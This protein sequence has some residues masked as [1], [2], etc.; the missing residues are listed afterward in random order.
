MCLFGERNKKNNLFQ[1][2][3]QG[4]M[5]LFVNKVL[6]CILILLMVSSI[7]FKL[8][9]DSIGY[10]FERK[11]KYYSNVEN[12]KSKRKDLFMKVGSILFFSK[13]A[14]VF[15]GKHLLQESFLFLFQ[16]FVFFCSLLWGKKTG[17]KLFLFLD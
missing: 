9:L 5:L 11:T 13:T 4:I 1:N 8:K 15:D 10:L 6:L 16:F 7:C 12:E 3:K 2:R 14:D 17:V